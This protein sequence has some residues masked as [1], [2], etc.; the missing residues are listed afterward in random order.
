[1]YRELFSC[2]IVKCLGTQQDYQLNNVVHKLL[3][4]RM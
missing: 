4:T 3:P 2:G 1:M